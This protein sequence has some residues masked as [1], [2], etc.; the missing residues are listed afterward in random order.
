MMVDGT[1]RYIQESQ[2]TRERVERML[3]DN[4]EDFNKTLQNNQNAL[5]DLDMDVMELSGKI[6][7]INTMVSLCHV[8]LIEIW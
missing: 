3:E 4:M 1:N 2:D 8:T 5:K 6:T 7:E